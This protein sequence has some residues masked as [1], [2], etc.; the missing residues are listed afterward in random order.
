[1]KLICEYRT[2]AGDGDCT[3]EATIFTKHINDNHKVIFKFCNS[4]F[5]WYGGCP[6]NH[7]EISKAEIKLIMILGNDYTIV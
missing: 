6:S 2:A 3:E 7:I 5:N 1:M 4:C